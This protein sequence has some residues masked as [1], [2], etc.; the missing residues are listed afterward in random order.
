[1]STLDNLSRITEIILDKDMT[2]D[3]VMSLINSIDVM[4]KSL[5]DTSPSFE[6]LLSS[7]TVNISSVLID[8]LD[9]L[10]IRKGS[11]DSVNALNALKASLLGIPVFNM[12]MAFYP[13]SEYMSTLYYWVKKN[14]GISKLNI[15]VN[16]N[17]L[18]GVIIDYSG[19]YIDKSL[20]TLVDTY[21]LSNKAYV[22]ELLR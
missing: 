14:I 15:T 16:P 6:N 21:L 19:R 8:V 18:G 13:D 1:M 9:Q 5:Y 20:N 17:L 2:Q 10:N 12:Q 4:Q 11:V 3:A 7:F 22:E